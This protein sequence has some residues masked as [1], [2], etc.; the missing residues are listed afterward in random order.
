MDVSRDEAQRAADEA[1]FREANER[2][3]DVQ[4]ELDPPA[5]QAPFLCECDDRACRAPILLSA[6]EYERVRSDAT[7][8]V[9]VS[10]HHTSGDVIEEADGYSIVRKSGVG[11]AVATELDTRQEQT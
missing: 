4:R 5:E 9:I 2:I 6:A 11:G 7:C 8:F 3:R 10:G 1:S